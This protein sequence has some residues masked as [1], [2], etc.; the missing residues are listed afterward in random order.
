MYV[1][2]I[3]F[4]MMEVR[5]NKIALRKLSGGTAQLRSCTP[6]KPHRGNIDSITSSFSFCADTQCNSTRMANLRLVS[7]MRLF[8]Q[9]HAALR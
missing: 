5:E 8:A 2:R 7:H 3:K 6:F 9:F 4:R 1:Y